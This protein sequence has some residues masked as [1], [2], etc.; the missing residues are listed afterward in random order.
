[1]GKRPEMK[2]W[3]RIMRKLKVL[4]NQ[5]HARVGVFGD[6]TKAATHEFGSK[7]GT[8]RERSFIRL[9]FAKNERDQKA[10]TAK[11]TKALV[12]TR[13]PVPKALDMLGMWGVEQVKK[14][15][16]EQPSEWPALS[17]AYAAKKKPT[18]TK[19]LIDEG[20]LIGSIT[21]EVKMRDAD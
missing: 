16:T 8:I 5:P 17:E 19:I 20:E 15:I 4:R 7:D 3:D 11:L 1:M 21:H 6:A 10:F 9:T 13:L 2:T 18:H 12:E 14:T